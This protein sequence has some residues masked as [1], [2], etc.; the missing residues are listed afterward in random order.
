MPDVQD[1]ID[2][3]NLH[4]ED[5]TTGNISPL[6]VRTVLTML[7]EKIGQVGIPE[8][9]DAGEALVKNSGD[10]FDV[11]WGEGTEPEPTTF[12]IKAGYSATDPYIDDLTAPTFTTL[13]T[14]TQDTGEGIAAQLNDM[15]T[16]Q[17]SVIEYDSTEPTATTW[18]DTSFN[19]GT[20]PDFAQRAVFS[21]G[22]KKYIV[23]RNPISYDT[24]VGHTVLFSH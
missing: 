9:G 23:S 5:N 19:N 7:A 22:G 8:G 12:T 16:L 4:I 3:I 15:P 10:D 21:V 11:V 20:I 17:Y 14:T 6:E 1:I 24:T 2:Y 13:H 18:Y